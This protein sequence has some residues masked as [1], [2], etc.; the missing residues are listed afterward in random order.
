M[1]VA[2]IGANS[3][4]ARNLILYIKQNYKNVILE[5]YD[6]QNSHLDNDEYKQVN[7]LDNKSVNCI[8][9]NTDIIFIFAGKTGTLNGFNEYESYIDINE[10]GLL[11]ILSE[12]KNQSSRAKIIF[13]SSRLV[14]KGASHPLKEIDEKEFKTIYAM[15]KFSCENYLKMFHQM[16]EINYLIFRICVPYGTLIQ[17]SSS[18]GTGEF[19]LKKAKAGE[20]ISLYGHGEVRRTLTHMEDL[21]RALCQGAFTET[22]VNE[23]F[24]IGGENYSLDEMAKRIALKY[25]VSVKYTNWPED[26]MKIESG[27][28]VFDSSKF[29]QKFNFSYKHKFSE[30]LSKE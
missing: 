9:F 14:Y 19:M 18:Y 17:N 26:A 21:C 25:G 30:I 10:K 12:F 8:D 23:I 11:N 15:N 27:D 1:K 22:C 28:T 29:D 3:F 2:I 13:P 20:D 5:L 7:I 16:Y 4:I 6:Y 24:N